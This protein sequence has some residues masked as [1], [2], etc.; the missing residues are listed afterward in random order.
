MLAKRN[1]DDEFGTSLEL[2]YVTHPTSIQALPEYV[3]ID[4]NDE[5]GAS[6]FS[7]SQFSASLDLNYVTQTWPEAY[8]TQYK[9]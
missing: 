6:Q 3:K 9:R 4:T 8:K 2:D 7:A 5:F 1:A